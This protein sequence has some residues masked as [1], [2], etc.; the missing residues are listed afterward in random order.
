MSTV[1]DVKAEMQIGAQNGTGRVVH[2]I[3]VGYP[4]T[5]GMKLPQCP[6]IAVV[7]VEEEHQTLLS[8][9]RQFGPCV[10]MA[11]DEFL[12]SEGA[13]FL[14]QL[15]GAGGRTQVLAVCGADSGAAPELLH[16]GCSGVLPE[17]SPVENVQRAI[18]AVAMGELWFPRK[19]LSNAIRALL[20]TVT[21]NRLTT[22]EREILRL[23]GRGCNNRVIA[24][25]LF[26]S[27]ETVRWHVRSLYAKIG[28]HDR[29]KVTAIALAAEERFVC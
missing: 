29:K 20:S 4:T 25:T 11:R 5:F 7:P 26:I 10:M 2:V 23:I 15:V 1:P 17:N 6:G 16:L 9:S 27:R 12:L 3:A 28:T 21:A 19:V 18:E 14:A 24:E 13:P 8:R 22:R